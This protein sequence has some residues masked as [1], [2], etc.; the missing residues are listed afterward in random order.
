[1]HRELRTL[2]LWNKHIGL[3]VNQTSPD[4]ACPV[5]VLLTGLFDVKAFLYAIIIK[6]TCIAE[7]RGLEYNG[8]MAQSTVEYNHSQ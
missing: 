8:F 7:F 3:C 1:M 5:A 2:N 4:S 6:Q